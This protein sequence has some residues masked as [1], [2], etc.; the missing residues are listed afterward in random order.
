MLTNREV[1][2]QGG[3][4]R[5]CATRSFGWFNRPAATGWRISNDAR[6]LATAVRQKDRRVSLKGGERERSSGNAALPLGFVMFGLRGE[7][8]RH[9]E[10]QTQEI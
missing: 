5:A 10:F 9:A 3:S 4:F 7:G 1:G 6:Q 8:A 2:A